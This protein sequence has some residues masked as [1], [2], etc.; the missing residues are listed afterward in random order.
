MHFKAGETE[1][2]SLYLI[3][4]GEIEIIA[5]YDKEKIIG[6]ERVHFFKL[7]TFLIVR[8]SE[9][10]EL[11]NFSKCLHTSSQLEANLSAQY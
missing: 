6:F 9:L 4:D 7:L 5:D 11:Q 2:Y 3:L 10:L 1:N 8:N